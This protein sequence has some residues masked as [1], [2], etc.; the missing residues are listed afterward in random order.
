ML[1]ARI[2]ENPFVS[3]EKNDYLD[4]LMQALVLQWK[5]SHVNLGKRKRKRKRQTD[6]LV[7]SSKA[8]PNDS[9]VEDESIMVEV[10]PPNKEKKWYQGAK[11]QKLY[12]RPAVRDLGHIILQKAESTQ[13][14]N[15][16]PTTCVISG[17]AGIGKSWSINAYM[18]MLLKRGKKIFFHSGEYGRAWM[19]E[20]DTVI[21]VDPVNIHALGPGWIYVYDSPGSTNLEGENKAAL[22][23]T[24][25]GKVSLIFSS[26]KRENYQHAIN[27][28]DGSYTIFHLPTW[29][30]KE[31]LDVSKQDYVGEHADAINVCY[32]I[33]GGNMRAWNKFKTLYQTDATRAIH[34]A[35]NELNANIRK[36]DK[37]FAKKM[38]S[39]LEKQDVQKKFSGVDVQDSPGH[40]L[41]PEPT[42]TDAE[43]EDCLQ[44]FRWH[45]CSPLAEKKF[46]R[47]MKVQDRDVLKDLLVSVFQVPSPRGVLFEKVAHHVVTNGVVQEFS[48]Y[49]YAKKGSEESMQFQ[50]CVEE[51]SFKGEDQLKAVLKEALGKLDNKIGSIACEPKDP[52]FDAVDM[53][54]VER[55]GTKG[56]ADDWRLYM[57]QDTISKTHSF[58]PVKVLWYCSVFCDVLKEELQ[59]EDGSG[60]LNCC[61]YIPVVPHETKDFSFK[62]ATA[63]CDLQE[64]DA[65]A[66]L[67][68]FKWPSE[69]TGPKPW[70]TVVDEHELLGWIPTTKDGS[71]RKKFDQK[72]VGNAM[73]MKHGAKTRVEKMC[74]VIFNVVNKVVNK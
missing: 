5:S 50:T 28:S 6:A 19:I 56:N 26:P 30:K 36:I 54:V 70:K 29:N 68:R 59:S 38:V 14:S 27:K 46:F 43:L 74:Q 24:G 47:H 13:T 42:Q 64:L 61:K 12:L 67:L 35:E 65:V 11:G 2:C 15:K 22:L 57:L 16:Q 69:Y 21:R 58:H 17:A 66:D 63:T 73:L 32:D 48:C 23:R 34:D 8:T 55:Q 62:S 40:I 33:W 41:V 60:L 4:A 45:F 37:E 9:G 20:A 39:N 49:P 3:T 10:Y 1:A 53:F 44:E 31:M 51:V 72:M 7:P 52:G 25:N 71:I 18:T